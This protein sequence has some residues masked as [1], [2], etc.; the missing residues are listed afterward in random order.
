M[1]KTKSWVETKEIS[2]FELSVPGP[3]KD[4][5]LEVFCYIKPTQKPPFGGLG[6]FFVWVMLLWAIFFMV[7]IICFLFLKEVPN[8]SGLENGVFVSVS[9]LGE[10]A[11]FGSLKGICCRKA[12]LVHLDRVIPFFLQTLVQFGSN[13]KQTTPLHWNLYFKELEK[14]E[15]IE[16]TRLKQE[17]KKTLLPSIP[18]QSPWPFSCRRIFFRVTC[19]SAD[20]STHC[21]RGHT[22]PHSSEPAMSWPRLRI[23]THQEGPA[24]FLRVSKPKHSVVSVTSTSPIDLF[25][26]GSCLRK[27]CRFTTKPFFSHPATSAH[28][29]LVFVTTWQQVC[30]E[31]QLSD[32]VVVPRGRRRRSAFQTRKIFRRLESAVFQAR[33]CRIF[34]HF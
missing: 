16:K 2:G 31:T 7:W 10:F 30:E 13:S 29:F 20:R 33:F 14:Q 15:K 25:P 12:T 32:R 1:K 4:Y 8:V 6:P 23:K 34:C 21:K 9:F 22:L 11:L 28:K 17:L 26:G 18:H 24:S 27:S 5:F 3:P 19:S